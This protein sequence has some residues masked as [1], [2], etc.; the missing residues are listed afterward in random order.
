MPQLRTTALTS[1]TP[2][3]VAVAYLPMKVYQVD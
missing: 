2:E 1:E 3:L